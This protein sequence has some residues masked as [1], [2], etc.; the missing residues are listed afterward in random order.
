LN[1]GGDAEERKEEETELD[2]EEYETAEHE[3]GY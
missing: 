1:A 2:E 3:E